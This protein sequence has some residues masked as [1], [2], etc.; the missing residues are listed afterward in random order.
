M[1]SSTHKETVPWISAFF[2]VICLLVGFVASLAVLNQ[3]LDPAQGRMVVLGAAG[4]QILICLLGFFHASRDFP[5][6][7]WMLGPVVLLCVALVLALIPDFAFS[8]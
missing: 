5:R 3:S 7:F 2:V 8:A 4:L 1:T 6:L